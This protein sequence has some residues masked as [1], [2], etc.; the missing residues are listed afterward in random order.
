MFTCF[1]C[2]TWNY[3]TKFITFMEE[4]MVVGLLQD[5]LLTYKSEQLINIMFCNLCMPEIQKMAKE[6]IFL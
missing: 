5:L 4:L 3:D 6:M 2:F 1:S